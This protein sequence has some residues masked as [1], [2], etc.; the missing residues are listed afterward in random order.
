MSDALGANPADDTDQG[1]APRSPHRHSIHVS[2]E[3]H[4]GGSP[5]SSTAAPSPSVHHEP[6]PPFHRPPNRIDFSEN[7]DLPRSWTPRDPLPE[8]HET[9]FQNRLAGRGPT[10][11]ITPDIENQVLNSFFNPALSIPQL[12]REHDVTVS[13]LLEW[14]ARPHVVQKIKAIRDFARFR[15][16]VLTDE[17]AVAAV[18]ALEQC[19]LALKKE[20]LHNPD[21]TPAT[22][23]RLLEVARKSATFLIR[24]S[25]RSGAVVDGFASATPCAVTNT[26]PCAAVNS[27]GAVVDGFASA[28]PKTPSTPA[29]PISHPP[30][31]SRTPSPLPT[32]PA[33]ASPHLSALGTIQSLYTPP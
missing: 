8:P 15:A 14:I 20:D 31:S 3:L 16:E 19:T 27:S 21:S 6:F 22:R 32:T 9:I 5:I 11:V 13:A 24:Q 30:P 4:Q 2:P 10:P 29:T 1:P 25:N 7:L 18:H 23:V 26:T 28:T 17:R 12:A 33:P